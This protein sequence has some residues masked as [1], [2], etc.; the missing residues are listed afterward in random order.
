MSLKK[1]RT[2]SAT[3]AEAAMV[4]ADDCSAPTAAAAPEE[5]EDVA[6]VRMAGCCGSGWVP[7]IGEL[8]DPA[9]EAAAVG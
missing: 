7:V 4:T 9:V 5:T 3:M 6:F 1:G 2:T 8:F